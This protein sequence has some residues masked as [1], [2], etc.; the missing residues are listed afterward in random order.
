MYEFTTLAA[1]K[2]LT[3][4]SYLGGTTKSVKHR[5]AKK[6]GAL[7]YSLYLAPAN[8]SGYEVCPGRTK[9]CTMFCLNESGMNTMVRDIAGDA[10]NDSRI[11]K[12]RLFFEHREFFMK[13]LIYEIKAA[14]RKANRMTY[15]FSVRINNTSD[16][17]P[18]GFQLDGKNILEIFPGIMFYDYTK[19]KERVELMKL[20]PNYNVTYSYNGYNLTECEKMLLNKINVAVVFKLVPENLWGHKVID[21][22]KNDLRYRDMK[23]VVI[24]LLYKRV[25]TR[26]T[27]NIKFV[28]Q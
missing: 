23:G 6:Y 13:W 22:D 24:G 9:E 8:S 16:I 12:T 18:E 7:T 28:I 4:L 3:G 1:A 19:I 17:S 11:T 21:G 15:E 2:R 27:S 5:K 10:I 20:Y 25:R 14:Q 26:L